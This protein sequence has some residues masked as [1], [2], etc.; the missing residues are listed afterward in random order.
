MKRLLSI[1]CCLVLVGSAGAADITAARPAA[2]R[3]PRIEVCFVLDTSVLPASLQFPNRDSPADESRRRVAVAAV[4]ALSSGL[5]AD[6]SSQPSAPQ[7]SR[8]R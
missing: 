6:T 3:K 2:P 8:P 5:E 7:S 1:V 4:P